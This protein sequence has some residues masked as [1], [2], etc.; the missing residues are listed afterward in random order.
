MLSHEVKLISDNEISAF[1]QI[2]L[3]NAPKRFWIEPASSTGKYH[4]HSSNG[5]SGL[6]MHTRQVF[7]IAKTILDTDVFD[8]NRDIVLSACLL[9]D[10]AKYDDDSKSKYTIYNHAERA[11]DLISSMPEILRF[12]SI[13]SRGVPDW[14]HEIMHCIARHDGKFNKKNINTLSAEQSIVHLA[15]YVA[16]RRWCSFDYE[17]VRK[18]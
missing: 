9:H 16:S 17:K 1:T 8:A 11:V 18:E 7:Y 15:D 10:I 14:F 3:N 5:V 6:V 12:I 4:P 13:Y 2:V